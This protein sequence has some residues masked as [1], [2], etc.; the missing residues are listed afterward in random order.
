MTDEEIIAALQSKNPSQIKQA[1]EELY[2]PL[3]KNMVRGFLYKN[4]S[5]SEEDVNEMHQQAI[6]ALYDNVIRGKYQQKAKLTTYIYRVVRNLWT[7]ELE[8][9]GKFNGSITDTEEF[10][11]YETSTF[12]QELEK[13]QRL[14]N[15]MA[16]F[17]K[18]HPECVELF[19]ATFYFQKGDG[20]IAAELQASQ[21]E[22]IST[23][24]V[25]TRRFR[26]LKKARELLQAKGWGLETFTFTTYGA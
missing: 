14:D 20:Q 16:E 22:N 21:N 25:R 24:T 7:T 2:K 26:C 13:Q 15:F 3:Y 4:S 11:T 8:R 18:E 23:T 1:F 10:A 17:A 9:R 6:I 19:K 12:E 5:K